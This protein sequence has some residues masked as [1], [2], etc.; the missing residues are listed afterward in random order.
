MKKIRPVPFDSFAH[1]E[2]D[3]FDK[4]DNCRVGSATDCTGLITVPPQDDSQMESYMNLY[5]FGP[6]FVETDFSEKR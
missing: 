4:F 5:D 3:K 2:Y 6:P 1:D